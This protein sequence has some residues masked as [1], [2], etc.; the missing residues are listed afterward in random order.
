MQSKTRKAIWDAEANLAKEETETMKKPNAPPMQWLHESDVAA[1]TGMSVH[2]LRAHR[3][4]GAG[5]RYAKIGRSVRY[6]L[7]DVVLFM[8]QHRVSTTQLDPDRARQ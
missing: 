6:A 4:H 3:Q 7:N 1:M 5:I 8:E 2:T